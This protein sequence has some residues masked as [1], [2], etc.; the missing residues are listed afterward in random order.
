MGIRLE[1][2]MSAIYS[3]PESAHAVLSMLDFLSGLFTEAGKETFTRD[4]LL[5]ILDCVR[6]DPGLLEPEAVIA[7][8]I[9]TASIE[10]ASASE[11]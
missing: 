9:A 10:E 8:E 5:V 11:L 2:G 1:A 7:F 6:C 3:D 4:E